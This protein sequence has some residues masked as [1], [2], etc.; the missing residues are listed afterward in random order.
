MYAAPAPVAPDA[1]AVP[2]APAHPQGPGAGGVTAIAGLTGPDAALI[3]KADDAAKPKRKRGRA[4][5]T[6]KRDELIGLMIG[7]SHLRAALVRDGLLVRVAEHPLPVGVIERGM[8]IDAPR[9]TAELKRF[10]AQAGFRTREVNFAISNRQ[11]TLRTLELPITEN[12]D[13]LQL[14]VTNMAPTVLEPINP[15]KAIIDFARLFR[16]GVRQQI[17]VAAG[18]REMISAYVTAVEKAGLKPVSCEIGPLAESRALVVSRSPDHAQGVVNVGAEVTTF[19]AASGP[20]VFFLRTID[21]GGN[22]FTRAVMRATDLDFEAADQLKQRAGLGSAPAD[23]TLDHAGFISAQGALLSVCDQLAQAIADSRRFYQQTAGG[24]VVDGIVMLGGGALLAG[25]TEQL[26]MELGVEQ[27]AEPRAREGLDGLRDPS[28]YAGAI[29]LASGHRMSLMPESKAS[30]LGLGGRRKLPKISQASARTQAR[31]LRAR[32]NGNP[33]TNPVLI[34][35]L[36]GAV[37]AGGCY[38]YGGKLKSANETL[39]AQAPAPAQSTPAGPPTYTGVNAE[40]ATHAAQLLNGS[41]DLTTLR[42]LDSAISALKLTEPALAV[43]GDQ[44]TFTGTAPNA[45]AVSELGQRLT[46]AAGVSA[47]TNNPPTA[48]GKGDTQR[49]AVT[50]RAGQFTKEP[51]K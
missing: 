26:T 33:T 30:A 19:V 1:P 47:L 9:L 12:D 37:L 20:D 34:G 14:A 27:I 43:T 10:W 28:A 44:V 4:E 11:V 25:L 40:Q 39:R 49:F 41:V 51:S 38:L 24:R 16:S 3:F 42:A 18:D 8:L 31:K 23:P 29:G 2:V 50:F 46:G 13:E 21:L 48:T 5:K 32:R 6:V 45:A 35:V 15:K 7:A 17:Q 36:I 22:D